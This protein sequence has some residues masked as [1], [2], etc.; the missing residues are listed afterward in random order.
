[1]KKSSM[2]IVTTGL[3][4]TLLGGCAENN[5]NAGYNSYE[6]KNDRE[7][8]RAINQEVNSLSDQDIAQLNKLK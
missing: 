5:Y 8:N 2:V 1:M 7:V 4:A 6:S 3:L